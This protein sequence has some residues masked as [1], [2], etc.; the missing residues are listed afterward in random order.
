MRTKTLKMQHVMPI[1]VFV[2]SSAIKWEVL[3]SSTKGDL[4]T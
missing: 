1:K 3:A 4:L 2:R